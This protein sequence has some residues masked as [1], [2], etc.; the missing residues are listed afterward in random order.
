MTE[1]NLTCIVCPVG[2]QLKVKLEDGGFISVSGNSCPRGAQYAENECTNP[3]RVITTTMRCE[4]GEIV[5][6]KTDR[7]I[8]KDKIFDCM[9]I[10]NN[11][12]CPLPISV[13]DVIIE[14]VF[15]SNIIATKNLT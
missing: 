9:K 6:V 14:D 7:A 3:V 8:P 1:K 11:S 5:P 2:C 10:I 4:N 13:G 12:I 15:G